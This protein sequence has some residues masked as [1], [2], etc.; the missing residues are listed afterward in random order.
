LPKGYDT[1][2]GESGHLLSGGECQR[3]AITRALLAKP[4]LLIFDEP[5]NHLDS[6]AIQKLNHSLAGLDYRPAILMISHDPR[7]MELA[8]EIYC[9]EQG[10]LMPRH[11]HQPAIATAG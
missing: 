4:K 7:V 10:A 1:E 5:T 9:L 2:I 6:E 11:A 8:S 3:I